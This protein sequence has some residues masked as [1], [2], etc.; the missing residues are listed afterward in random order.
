MWRSRE[1][2]TEVYATVAG[3]GLLMR[4]KMEW[5]GRDTREREREVKAPGLR[6]TR[7][8]RVRS[9]LTQAGIS[10]EDVGGMVVVDVE[11][12]MTGL[13]EDLGAWWV[14]L[15]LEAGGAGEVMA[16]GDMV[17]VRC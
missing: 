15:P 2:C 12:V 10:F 4:A 13:V 6:S 1:A 5:A 11:L 16:A 3:V 8:R 9:G 14:P 7:R 17:V